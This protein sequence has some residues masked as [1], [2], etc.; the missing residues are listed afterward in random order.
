MN[1]HDGELLASIKNPPFERAND[2]CGQN[3]KAPSGQE[4]V[5]RF[6]KQNKGGIIKQS[7]CFGDIAFNGMCKNHETY[8]SDQSG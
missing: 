5:R 4:A 2:G 7:V 8:K 1:L 6:T 3:K